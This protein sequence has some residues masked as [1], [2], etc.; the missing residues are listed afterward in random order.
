MVVD[1]VFA[2]VRDAAD[3]GA[4]VLL[5]EQQTSRALSIADRAYVMRR[6]SVLAGAASELALRTPK[7]SP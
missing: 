5:M 4:G 7:V 3:A 2:S 6:G 1:R